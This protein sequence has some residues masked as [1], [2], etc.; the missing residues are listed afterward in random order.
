RVYSSVQEL[1]E[2]S[3][4]LAAKAALARLATDAKDA[5]LAV[6]GQLLEA[7]YVPYSLPHAGLYLDFTPC[8][9]FL[10]EE[11]GTISLA[12]AHEAWDE[13]HLFAG[14]AAYDFT[15]QGDRLTMPQPKPAAG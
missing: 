15:P 13:F 9:E 1:D 2:S 11:S 12:L 10:H 5:G 4:Y 7:G 8:K 6:P 14:G 3:R